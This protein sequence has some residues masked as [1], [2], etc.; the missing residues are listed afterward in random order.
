MTVEA[1]P[2]A[3]PTSVWDLLLVELEQALTLVCTCAGRCRCSSASPHPRPVKGCPATAYT[4]TSHWS[5]WTILGYVAHFAPTVVV[6]CNGQHQKFWGILGPLLLLAYCHC[7]FMTLSTVDGCQ[8]SLLVCTATSVGTAAQTR[9]HSCNTLLHYL[10][11]SHL[12]ARL[13]AAGASPNYGVCN[14]QK[15]GPLSV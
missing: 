14:R 1:Q 7:I 13:G 11:D 10:T 12:S 8:R 9:S 4:L 2:T 5:S 15:T 6:L 3:K